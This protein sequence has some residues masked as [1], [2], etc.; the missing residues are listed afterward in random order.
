MLPRIGQQI[1]V[2]QELQ[3]FVA[4]QVAQLAD[5][6]S[7]NQQHAVAGEPL[8]VPHHGEGAGQV[9]EHRGVLAS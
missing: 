3:P 2:V 7:I 4:R 5:A 6:V 8:H 9:P 1:H